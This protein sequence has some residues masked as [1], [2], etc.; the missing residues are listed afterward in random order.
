MDKLVFTQ[1][2]LKRGNLRWASPKKHGQTDVSQ[3]NALFYPHH[4]KWDKYCFFKF[5]IEGICEYEM[6]ID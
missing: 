6:Q 3:N 4:N 1:F 5:S 2:S